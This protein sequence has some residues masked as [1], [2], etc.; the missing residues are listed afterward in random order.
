MTSRVDNLARTIGQAKMDEHFGKGDYGSPTSGYGLQE[1]LDGVPDRVKNVV[2]IP[3]DA[4]QPDPEQP[5]K[6]FDET[7]LQELAESLKNEGQ[8]QP[9]RVLK[10]AD[11]Q[12][13]YII[14]MGERRY[15]AAKL[16]GLPSLEA[17]IHKERP[18][19]DEKLLLAWTENA[20]RRDLNPIEQGETFEQLL[21]MRGCG[22][23]ELGRMLHIDP[24]QI[25][26]ARKLLSLP[27]DIKSLVATGK[28]PAS[29]AQELVKIEDD[30]KRREYLQGYLSGAL[31]TTQ[32]ADE[33]HATQDA[34]EPPLV[35]GRRAAAKTKKAVIGDVTITVSYRAKATNSELAAALESF[36]QRLLN[37]GRSRRVA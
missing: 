7:A 26:K 31:S 34:E 6:T 12:G 15:R 30:Q 22:V 3:L 37:D 1:R 4:M 18:Q 25:S 16:A 33:R 11:Q 8:L 35:P 29:T 13:R 19:A 17:V 9:I 14:L 10:D 5:R 2:R 21:A 20:H 28:V 32:M 23:R 36:A 27:D 24:T